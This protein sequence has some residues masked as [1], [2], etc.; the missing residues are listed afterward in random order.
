[1]EWR[2]NHGP[3]SVVIV[4]LVGAA[5]CRRGEAQTM[6]MVSVGTSSGDG[7]DCVG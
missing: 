4:P 6:T 1:M 3:A 5:M 2:I 7:S